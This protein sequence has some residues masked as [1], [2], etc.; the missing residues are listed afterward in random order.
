ERESM[1]VGSRIQEVADLYLQGADPQ[2]P[3]ASPLYG[4]LT[5]LP[6]TLIQ[7]SDREILLDDSRRLAE[8]VNAA[9]GRAELSVWPNLPHVWQI[10]QSFLPEARQA[11]AQ[12]ADFAR[13]ALASGPVAA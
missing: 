13:S 9:G 3:F 1:L 6:P 2:T 8:K 11:L 10:S 4:D 7:V 12:A 5:G